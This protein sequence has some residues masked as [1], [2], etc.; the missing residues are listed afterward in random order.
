M[1]WKAVGGG[2]DGTLIRWQT[3]GQTL[4]G[5]YRGQKDGKYGPLGLMETPGGVQ[6]FAM[7]TV[8]VDRFRLI[9]HDAL[10]KI[11]YLGKQEGKTG[12]AFHAFNVFVDDTVELKEESDDVP[13]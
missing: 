3:T 10:V 1:G 4:E 6:T 9:P 7:P 11:V 8:L 5:T 12:Q 13:F 2:G